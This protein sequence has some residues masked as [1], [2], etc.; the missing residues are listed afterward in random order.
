MQV[1]NL[2]FSSENIKDMLPGFYWWVICLVT[3]MGP[4]YPFVLHFDNSS[5]KF[6]QCSS[7]V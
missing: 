1:K 7:G 5:E 2:A 3:V 6:G 4:W